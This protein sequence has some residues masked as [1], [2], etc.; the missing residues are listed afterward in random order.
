MLTTLGRLFPPVFG[1]SSLFNYYYK[2]EIHMLEY[3]YEL[4]VTDKACPQ[5]VMQTKQLLKKMNSGEV[6]HVMATDPV[7]EQDINMLL[8]AIADKLIEK[9]VDD[10]VFHFYIEKS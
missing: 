4:D 6:L 7:A 10:G 8:D 9:S 3:Q 2:K 1:V 5:P